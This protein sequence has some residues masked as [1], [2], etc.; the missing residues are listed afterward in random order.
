MVKSS[1]F[2]YEFTRK[3]T[4]KTVKKPQ[5]NSKK[6][7]KKP[8]KNRKKQ[9]YSTFGRGKLVFDEGFLMNRL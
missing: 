2:V 6:T 3:D 4:K 5:K 9:T 1:C 8:Q 7:A